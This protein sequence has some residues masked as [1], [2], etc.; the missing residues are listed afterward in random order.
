MLVQAFTFLQDLD[1]LAIKLS[2]VTFLQDRQVSLPLGR[3]LDRRLVRDYWLLIQLEF[4]VRS[5][6]QF[7]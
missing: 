2:F 3:S 4:A 5:N 7:W 1:R 6:L